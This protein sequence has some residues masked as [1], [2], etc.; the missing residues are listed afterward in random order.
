MIRLPRTFLSQQ[1]NWCYCEIIRKQTSPAAAA[2]KM[3]IK[4]TAICVA[5]VPLIICRQESENP[6][7]SVARAANFFGCLSGKK[8]AP[9]FYGPG[10]SQLLT[11]RPL[12][13]R[14]HSV[15]VICWLWIRKFL[16]GFLWK[17]LPSNAGFSEGISWLCWNTAETCRNTTLTCHPASNSR[18]GVSLRPYTTRCVMKVFVFFQPA[19]T[20]LR[21]TGSRQWIVFWACRLV[22]W[23][24]QVSENT[25]PDDAPHTK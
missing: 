22:R 7:Q 16:R 1:W 8:L 24:F 5:F 15:A 20:G 4:L 13:V 11:R 2:Q 19:N 9:R 21:P 3:F 12:L 25:P 18:S 6:E 10:D 17:R 14:Q 23:R